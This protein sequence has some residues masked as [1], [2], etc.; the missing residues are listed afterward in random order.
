M[1]PASMP[2]TI[3]IGPVM[4]AARRQG[5]FF[6]LD[7]RAEIASWRALHGAELSTPRQPTQNRCHGDNRPTTYCRSPFVKIDLTQEILLQGR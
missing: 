7:R 5:V 3:S 4:A 6:R 2:K 1:A